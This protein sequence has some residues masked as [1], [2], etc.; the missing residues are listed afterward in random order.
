LEI[1]KAKK[2]SVKDEHNIT[3]SK[4]DKENSVKCSEDNFKKQNSSKKSKRKT[5]R[6]EIF[7]EFEPET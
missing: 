5:V 4:E 6:Y 1:P 7:N 2:G 3:F